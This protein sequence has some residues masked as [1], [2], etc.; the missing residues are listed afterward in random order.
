[1]S[2]VSLGADIV[3]QSAHKTLPAMTMGSFL[4]FNSELL[5]NHK[6]KNNLEIFQSSSPSYPIMASLDIARHY[7]AAYREEDISYL[8]KKITEFKKQL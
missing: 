5:S 8:L 2:A 4:H 6:V 3:V 1:K 7:L